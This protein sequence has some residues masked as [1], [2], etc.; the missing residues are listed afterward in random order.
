MLQ[1]DWY[2]YSI[3]KICQKSQFE[4]NQQTKKKRLSKTDRKRQWESQLGLSY[5]YNI[6]A[7]VMYTMNR[8]ELY[9]K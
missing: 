2:I 1:N 8:M 5:D 3:E 7:Y 6:Y 4:E 9:I